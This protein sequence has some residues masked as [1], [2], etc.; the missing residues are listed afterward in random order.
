MPYQ[1]P[2]VR[3]LTRNKYNGNN[4]NNSFPRNTIAQ[5]GEVS[6]P[7]MPSKSNDSNMVNVG[8]LSGPRV[9]HTDMVKHTSSHSPTQEPVL[10]PPVRSSL[11]GK[12]IA[13]GLGFQQNTIGISD[14]LAVLPSKGGILHNSSI[15]SSLDNSENISDDF[16]SSASL[17][18]SNI[19]EQVL[20]KSTRVSSEDVSS[21]FS[22]VNTDIPP[23]G[24]SVPIVDIHLAACGIPSHED[25]LFSDSPNELPCAQFPPSTASNCKDLCQTLWGC[26]SLK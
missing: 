26:R 5:T 9:L 2:L 14:S 25:K 13:A 20:S 7:L 19:T 11:V 18:Y 12:R 15:P 17:D 21:P 8:S 6:F 24:D 1:P 10:V 16:D 3:T 4:S 23:E 22:L